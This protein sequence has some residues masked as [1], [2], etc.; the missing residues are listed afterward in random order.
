VQEGLQFLELLKHDGD[1]AIEYLLRN[2]YSY[3][4]K[5]V[6]LILPNPVVV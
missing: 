2:D 6:Y 5:V 1:A 4:C 3:L